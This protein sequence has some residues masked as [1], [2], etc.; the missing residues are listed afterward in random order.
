MNLLV[1]LDGTLTDP[2]LGITRCLEHALSA[3]GQPVP[4]TLTWCVGPPLRATFAQLLG[5]ADPEVL[6]R[7]IGLYRER[8]VS[9]GMFENAVYPGVVAG[10]QELRH[11][12]HQLRVVT[13][14]PHVYARR[15]LDHFALSDAFVS[16]HGSELSGEFADKADLIRHVL[17]TE[18]FEDRPH[19]VGDR[20]HDIEAAHANSLPG[21]GVLWG[22]GSGAELEAAGADTLV[23]SMDQ[24]CEWAGRQTIVR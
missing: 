12:G 5:S 14:K 9:V 23:Q 16:I 6:D 18:L 1:D 22:Y 8:F 13:S 15:I 21:V 19:M 2:G 24:L 7:A 17:S 4:G 3:L 20:R 10:L 11:A